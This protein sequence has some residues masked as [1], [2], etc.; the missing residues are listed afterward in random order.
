MHRFISHLNDITRTVTDNMVDD[1]VALEKIE[2]AHTWLRE[3]MV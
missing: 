2:A 3:A 1:G